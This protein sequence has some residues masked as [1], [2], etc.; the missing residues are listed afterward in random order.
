MRGTAAKLCRA[1]TGT[2]TGVSALSGYCP[3]RNGNL[4]AFSFIENGVCTGCAKALEDRMVPLIASY[5]G[6]KATIPVGTTPTTP[7]TPT[8][9]TTPTTPTTPTKPTTPTT[10]PTTTTTTIPVPP[11]GGVTAP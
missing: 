2:L 10:I 6:S 11:G 5:A 9:P 3:A 4:V 8:R 1:K 7:T